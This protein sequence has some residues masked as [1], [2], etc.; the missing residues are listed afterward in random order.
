MSVP[1]PTVLLKRGVFGLR[2]RSALTACP[3]LPSCFAIS[4][5]GWAASPIGRPGPP[6]FT[7]RFI[8]TEQMFGT[9][10]KSRYISPLRTSKPSPLRL[11]ATLDPSELSTND[12]HAQNCLT[13]H[14]KDFWRWWLKRPFEDEIV[15][16]VKEMPS[17]NERKEKRKCP[18]KSIHSVR[19]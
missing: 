19:H 7:D 3:P 9:N 12:H 15:R 18:I 11:P 6:Q 10:N 17:Q 16:A 8:N 2:R 14:L 1:S 13:S 4:K 5:E